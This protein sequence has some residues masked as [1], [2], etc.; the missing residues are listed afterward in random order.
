MTW[1][2]T[3]VSVINNNLKPVL[4]DINTNNSN[5]NLNELKITKKTKV[6][7]VVH[8]YG[9]PGEIYKIKKIIGDKK[10]KIIEDAAQ[11]HGAEE[12]FT[13]KKIGS[14][15]DFGCFSFYPGKNLGAYGDAGCITTNSKNLY[16]KI[17]ELRNIGL[18]NLKNKSDCREPVINSRLDTIQAV[19]LNEKLKKLVYLNENRKLISI[20]I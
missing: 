9:N 1:K 11:A 15:G 20:D 7:I 10:I 8:L 12:T 18:F 6:I 16:K 5:L 4:V 2:S 13:K 19:V 14:I 3:L 17:L